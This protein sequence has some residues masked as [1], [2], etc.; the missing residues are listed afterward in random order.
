M[1]FIF[2][3]TKYMQLFTIKTLPSFRIRVHIQRKSKTNE[4]IYI[5]DVFTE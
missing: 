5:L 2:A 4:N 1:F 3:S